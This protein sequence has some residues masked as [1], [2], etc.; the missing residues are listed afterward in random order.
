L[1]LHEAAVIDGV[2]ARIEEADAPEVAVGAGGGA[3]IDGDWCT[4]ESGGDGCGRE[5]VDVAG[6]CEV[7]AADAEVAEG[8]GV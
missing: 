7:D 5:M 2:A 8:D 1:D 6:A 4:V 3:D